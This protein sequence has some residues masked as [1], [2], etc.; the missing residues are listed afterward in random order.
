MDNIFDL[1]QWTG[2]REPLAGVDSKTKASLT[3]AYNKSSAPVPFAVDMKIKKKKKA[4]GASADNEDGESAEESEEELVQFWLSFLFCI[5]SEEA[6]IAA[7]KKKK[8]A[9]KV[10]AKKPAAKKTKK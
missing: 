9:K 4:A 2:T 3:R 6:L 10:T 5:F 8:P 1:T 7:M